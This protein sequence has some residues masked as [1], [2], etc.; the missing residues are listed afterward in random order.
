MSIGLR[1]SP[2]NFAD[3]VAGLHLL[4]KL[5]EQG[6]RLHEV[7]WSGS[8]PGRLSFICSDLGLSIVRAASFYGPTAPE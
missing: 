4:S 1:V 8:R 6:T 3:S 5:L 7:Q 2:Q